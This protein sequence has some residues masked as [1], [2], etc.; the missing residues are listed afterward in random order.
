MSRKAPT[1]ATLRKLF[2]LSGNQCAYPQCNNS[3]IED[4]VVIGEICHI[5]AAEELGTRFNK[6]SSDEERRHFS[7]LI[8]LCPICHK[9]IDA[10][11]G[12]YTVNLLKKWKREHEQRFTQDNFQVSDKVIKK[13]IERFMEQNNKNEGLGS[14]FNNQGDGITINS[15]IGVQN[16]FKKDSQ[17][18]PIIEY[19]DEYRK[20]MV[21]FKRELDL[22]IKNSTPIDER[23]INYRNNVLERKKSKV[24]SVPIKLLRYRKEN[25]RI[26]SEV[27]SYERTHN[28]TI[29]EI[30]DQAI[31]KDFLL[32]NDK[33]Q[34]ERLKTLLDSEGQREP[35][36]VTCDGFLINGNRRR[37]AF[38][39]LWEHNHQDS[40]FASMNVVILDERVEL[41]EIERIENRYQ[42]Q[43]EG[44]SEYSGLNRALSIRDKI[45]NGYTLEAQLKDDPLYRGK[46]QKE[47]NKVV[48]E[49]VTNY[50]NPLECVD[51]YLRYFDNEGLYDLVSESI[52][53]SEGRWQAFIDYS[54]FYFNVLCNDRQRRKARIAKEDIGKIKDVAFK[55]IRK[56]ELGD[57]GSLYT[58]IRNLKKYVSNSDAKKNLFNIVKDVDI[59]IPAELK[60]NTK[61]K[62]EITKRDEDKVWGNHFKHEIL[63]NLH[64]AHRVVYLKD[65]HDRPLDLLNQA[66]KKLEHDNLDIKNITIDDINEAIEVVTRVRD[67][68]EEL[69]AEMDKYRFQ[70]KKWNK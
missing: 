7:N 38:E 36:V 33:G 8:L 45:E 48:K 35:A 17:D 70:L 5:E 58:V 4:D 59:K 22:V 55:L 26:K 53:S 6:N 19:G 49:Y 20:V 41:I 10:D 29:D 40:R 50:L 2:G 14:Q 25:G 64:K 1:T 43:D 24:Y 32:K 16:I 30:K 47:L 28:C 3:L 13:S 60:I 57:L 31:L 46:N 42:L 68:A 69:R 21:E 37:A 9:K 63:S 34:T 51:E 67:K 39:E 62:E 44:K 65:E 15:Q 27:K 18:E 66:L 61:S 56:R 54:K 12:K 11:D 52:G 23:T